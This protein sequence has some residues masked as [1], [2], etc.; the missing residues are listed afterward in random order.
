MAEKNQLQAMLE[1]LKRDYAEATEAAAILTAKVGSKMEPA[2]VM[3]RDT[4]WRLLKAEKVEGTKIGGKFY[5]SRSSLNRL[6]ASG[7]TPGTFGTRDRE[8]KCFNIWLKSDAALQAQQIAAVKKVLGGDVRIEARKYYHK[9][10]E[11]K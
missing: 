9:K 2:R 10:K 3:K 5:I 4:V 1:V 6:V 11:E 7:W 8:F